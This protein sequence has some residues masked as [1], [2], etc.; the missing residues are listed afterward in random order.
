VNCKRVVDS[1]NKRCVSPTQ[2]LSFFRILSPRT[3][4]PIDHASNEG[5]E[6]QEEENYNSLPYERI[7]MV[8]F[9]CGGGG[10][11][12]AM[13]FL[14]YVSFAATPRA[15][16]PG[17]CAVNQ[18]SC[19]CFHALADQYSRVTAMTDRV[20]R[21]WWITLSYQDIGQA[22]QAMLRT[23]PKDEPA[24]IVWPTMAMWASNV[25]GFGIRGQMIDEVAAYWRRSAPDWMQE[26]MTIIPQ[27]ADAIFKDLLVH[28]SKALGGGNHIVFEQIGGSYTKYGVAFCADSKY[29]ETKIS[30]FLESLCAGGTC[31]LALALRATYEAQFLN[32]D[33]SRVRSQLLFVQSMLAGLQEQ[34][35]LQSYINASLP[36]YDFCY[37]S[38]TFLSGDVNLEEAKRILTKQNKKAAKEGAR[39]SV[40]SDSV[41]CLAPHALNELA[42]FFFIHLLIGS[43]RM[44]VTSPVP[45]GLHGSGQNF[46]QN[47]RDLSLLPQARSIWVAM[48][49]NHSDDATVLDFT[50]ATDWNDLS[51]R[52]R[53]ISAL[54]RIFQDLPEINCF[55]FSSKQE[56]LI[57][58]N[59][60]ETLDPDSWTQLC[61]ADCCARNGQWTGPTDQM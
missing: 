53:Y 15:A 9:R 13:F 12:L 31:P 47:L 4:V 52:M 30:D 57:R 7:G 55:P 41:V 8:C 50:A 19:A 48:Q 25:V 10:L 43:H 21:N 59:T 6:K 22:F 49:Y 14:F 29:N 17:A 45:F 28:T 46:S 56:A 44:P 39:F 36:G 1:F 51:Q 23:A 42:T 54:F 11:L 3:S 61:V 35:R 5:E 16:G 26:L 58:S 33:S 20:A 37:N 34:T 2:H 18:S 27:L 38:S 32:H 60:T 40:R 24:A